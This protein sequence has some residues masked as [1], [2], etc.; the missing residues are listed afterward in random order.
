MKPTK[1]KKVYYQCTHC[2]NFVRVDIPDSA[3]CVTYD[4]L[5][6]K[7]GE[8]RCNKCLSKGT[9]LPIDVEVAGI[10][11]IL[12][13][14]GYYTIAGREA[15]ITRVRFP[16]MTNDGVRYDDILEFPSIMFSYLV[17]PEMLRNVPS[18]WKLHLGRYLNGNEYCS[19]TYNAP[20]EPILAEDPK[21][22][23]LH[24]IIPE[25]LNSLLEWAMKLG[26]AKYI[27]S[28]NHDKIVSLDFKL[29]NRCSLCNSMICELDGRL[30][31]IALN[32][33]AYSTKGIESI[34]DDF[35]RFGFDGGYNAYV[36]DDSITRNSMLIERLFDLMT[37]WL[38]ETKFRLIDSSLDK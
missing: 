25:A 19:I 8:N 36:I 29:M 3:G 16:M 26:D 17:K 38:D 11:E 37:G 10:C 2:Q 24:S 14:K 6:E 35:Y 34:F 18:G 5:D 32:F 21:M 12:S 9:M 4:D 27:F 33:G 30:Y 22:V 15:A 23:L 13:R 31:A 28:F 1:I 7:L 20:K